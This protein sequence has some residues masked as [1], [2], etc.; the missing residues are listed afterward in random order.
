[1]D[2]DDILF[3]IFK[4]LPLKDLVNSSEV[5]SQFNSIALDNSIWH[6][7]CK[8]DYQYK[9]NTPQYIPQCP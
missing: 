9:G 1:M 4:W 2:N 3:E 5:N 8:A 6:G 7:K